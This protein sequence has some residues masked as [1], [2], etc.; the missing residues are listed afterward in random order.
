MGTQGG[1]FPS[2]GVVARAGRRFGLFSFSLLVIAALAG[3]PAVVRGVP[4]ESTIDVTTVADEFGT[5]PGKCSLREAVQAA[6]LGTEFGGCTT[7]DTHTIIE[8]P[9][10]TY[11]LTIAGAGEDLNV[12]GDLDLDS[13]ITI[14]GAGRATTIIDGKEL[15]RVLHVL[16]GPV[17]LNDLTVRGGKAPDGS[18]GANTPL[19]AIQGAP[20]QGETGEHGGGIYNEASLTI[21]DGA[22]RDNAAGDG[23]QG[24]KGMPGAPGTT[25]G[26]AGDP[27]SAGAPGGYGGSGGGIYNLAGA[28]LSL[29]NTIVADNRAGNGG[30]GG[31]G[32]DGGQGAEAGDGGDGGEGGEGGGGGQGGGIRSDAAASVSLIDCTLTD[33]KAG[34]G[35]RAGDGGQAG[36]AGQNGQ[37]GDGGNGGRGG[38]GARGGALDSPGTVVVTGTRF[39][40]NESGQGGRGGD[41]GDVPV[42]ARVSNAAPGAA[43]LAFVAGNGGLGGLGG[44]GGNGGAIF[45]SNPLALSIGTAVV[46]GNKAGDGA[47]GG[48]GGD[49]GAG[50]AAQTGGD[51]GAGG[52][53]GYGGRGGGISAWDSLDMEKCSVEFNSAG[54]G[55]PGGKGGAG[56]QGGVGNTG[57]DGGD[58]GSGD[59]GGAGGA[60]GHGGGIVLDGALMLELSTVS[61][62]RAG[63]G[64]QGGMGGVGGMGGAGGAEGGNGG[65][66]GDGG[67]SGSGGDGG[68]GGG[69]AQYQADIGE[70]MT[71]TLAYNRAGN[72]GPSQPGASGGAGGAGGPAGGGAPAGDLGNNGDGGRGGKGG[73]GGPGGGLVLWGR[74]SVRNST[75]AYNYAHHG[76]EGSAGGAA[77]VGGTVGTGEGGN[78]GDGGAGGRG[79]GIYNANTLYLDNVTISGNEAGSGGDGADGGEGPGGKMGGGDGGDAGVG[80]GLYNYTNPTSSVNMSNVTIAHNRAILPAGKGGD[81]WTVG[82][83]GQVGLGGGVFNEGD[84][85]FRHSLIAN[86]EAQ[87][88]S[89]DCHGDMNSFNHNLVLVTAAECNIF[90]LQ[91]NNIYG[92]YP[93]ISQLGPNG[94]PTDTHLPQPSSPALDGGA[95]TCYDTSGSELK[96]DQRG[97][98]RPI[99]GDGVGAEQCDIGAVEVQGYEKMQAAVDGGGEGTVQTSPP[100]IGCGRSGTACETYFDQNTKVIATALPYYGQGQVLA[101]TGG[102]RFVAWD[103]DCQGTDITCTVT[104]D[105]PKSITATFELIP[106]HKLTV[107]VEG[108]GEGEVTSDPPGI[109]CGANVADCD[110]VYD[111][112]TVVTLTAAAGDNSTFAGWSGA[113]SGRTRPAR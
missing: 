41:G 37:D 17:R 9:A 3:P 39:E 49:G 102:S 91:T 101:G 14:N 92:S 25:P 79:G 108:D 18:D 50:V 72:G 26:Q 32:G 71:T 36:L 73:N 31:N 88:A 97:R 84:L 40:D 2:R 19:G 29:T 87:G 95:N 16:S 20:G 27:G 30:R 94:G 10:G 61:R 66:G 44:N 51:G 54:T 55:G 6:N 89:K 15:D 34:N 93:M 78:G 57:A 8:L 77:G 67:W 104:M 76:A 11:E 45:Y 46:K 65:R 99:D 107:L 22:V 64:G 35:A 59:A 82:V 113:C 80:G 105:G 62:N 85:I 24:A 109:A 75:V 43:P 47:A 28:N 74:I 12:K 23:G 100:G 70:V 4:P 69:V 21:N 83:D 106:T 13:R 52:P 68:S 103:G 96:A 81:G 33:N 38:K 58:G 111:E 48:D 110:E 98:P 5:N 63:D 53:G 86:N 90:G 112:G 1:S 7:G 42:L 60:G 56:G